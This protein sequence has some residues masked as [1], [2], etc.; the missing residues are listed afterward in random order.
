MNAVHR[1]VG[2][3]SDQLV[4]ELLGHESPEAVAARPRR[5]R[6]LISE[7]R[8]FPG[9]GDLLRA[10]H[11]KGL[12]VVIASSAAA[13]ELDAL[14][15][16]LHAVEAIDASTSA[17]DVETSKPDPE[18]FLEAMEMGA[19][20]PKTAPALGDSIWDIRAARAARLGCV[21]VETGGYSAHELR[22]EGALP[23][24]RDVAELLDQFATSPLTSLL[25]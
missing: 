25:R 6:E 18:V 22:E 12:A 2:M 8:P 11:Q 14:P 19:V 16:R 9:A 15:E 20:D 23:V 13:D 1:L 4:V 7:A 3:G 17:D 24:Y 5:Y 10:C 21:A